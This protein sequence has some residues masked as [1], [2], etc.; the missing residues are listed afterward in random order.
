MKKLLCSVCGRP[1]RPKD[2]EVLTLTLEEKKLMGQPAPDTLAYCKPCWRIVTHRERG[3]KFMQGLW[4]TSLRRVG[5]VD[6]EARAK[7]FH[8]DLLAK[9]KKP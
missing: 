6:A 9:V 2:C 4:E 3:A 5:V 1:Q 8:T 7:K